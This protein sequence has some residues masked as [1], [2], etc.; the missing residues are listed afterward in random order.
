MTPWFSIVPA[1]LAAAAVV[2]VPGLLI[3]VALRLRGLWLWATA[4]P[5]SVSVIAM[6]SVILS[7]IGVAWG[8]LSVL[9]VSLVFAVLIGLL[10]RL[11]FKQPEMRVADHAPEGAPLGLSRGAKV[12][13]VSTLVLVSIIMVWRIGYAIGA[14]DNISQTFDNIFHL[15][16]VQFVLDQGDASPLKIGLMNSPMGNLGFYPSGWHA[17]VS[18]V[19]DLSGAGVPVATNAVTLAVAAFIWGAGVVLLTRTLLGRGIAVALSAAVLSAGFPAFPML[20]IA[21]G[22]LYPMFLGFSMVPAVLAVVVGLIGF[23]RIPTTLMLPTRWLLLVGLAPG[24]AITHPGALMALLACTVP[25]VLVWSFNA[26]RDRLREGRQVWSVLIS[27]VLYLAGGFAL[28]MV[29]RP[30][31]EQA[32]W[33]PELGPSDAVLQFLTSQLKR[34][35]IPYVV[36]ALVLIGVIVAILRHDRVSIAMLG[37]YTVAATLFIVAAG[38]EHWFPRFWITGIWYQNIP[39][40]ESITVFA[41]LPLAVLGLSTIIRAVAGFAGDRRMVAGGLTL[42]IAFGVLVA[43]Q[44]SGAVRGAT[45]YIHNNFSYSDDADLVSTDELELLR[46]LPDEV[47]ANATI[48]GNGWTGAGMAYAIANRWVTMPHVM[49]D[50]TDDTLLINEKLR[51]ATPGSD[52]CQAIDDENVEFVLDFGDREV[53]EGDHAMPGLDNLENSTAVQLVDD[54]GDA[55]LYRVVGCE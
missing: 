24:L 44:L 8:V 53:H 26:V 46:R 25:F 50:F 38:I 17:V 35:E 13:L 29:V 11:V 6:S 39:R 32:F 1:F 20:M 40:I 33:P 19:V 45:N 27:T 23:E 41:T 16:A 37:A 30:P 3:G 22:V 21:Y 54:E 14:P 34:G 4:G 55:K 7:F 42:L 31:R 52:V 51:D 2:L 36:G 5:I 48:A 43:T 18:L 28:F 9:A 10:V 15:N 47:P 12:S 49:I